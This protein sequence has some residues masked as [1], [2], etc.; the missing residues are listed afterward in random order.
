MTFNEV[1]RIVRSL[2]Q[3]DVLSDEELTDHTNAL[4]VTL[5]NYSLPSQMVTFDFDGT[6]DPDADGRSVFRIE[7]YPGEP[8]NWDRII[9][10]KQDRG[11]AVAGIDS[12]INI[13]DDP[14]FVVTGNDLTIFG[15]NRG[16]IE[17]VEKLPFLGPAGLRGSNRLL[18]RDPAI[19]IRGVHMQ[20]M[21]AD[22]S[23]QSPEFASVQGFFNDA[24]DALT[25]SKNKRYLDR[26]T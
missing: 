5:D 24:L 3:R 20:L 25:A 1:F 23:T 11:L 15:V 19:Y 10:I 17:A 18:D 14:Y 12:E 16:V 6:E 9:K 7:N 8:H 13:R 21:I 26:W 2:A 4:N 22:K